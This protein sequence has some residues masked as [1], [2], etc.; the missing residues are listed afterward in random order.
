MSV[1]VSIHDVAPATMPEVAVL[2]GMAERVG[3]PT[4]LLVVP[5]PWRP[6]VMAEA[7]WFVDELHR[8]AGR[9]HEIVVHGWEH[10]AVDDPARSVGRFE[11]SAGRVLTR[12]CAE[13]AELGDREAAARVRSGL[14]AVRA[15]GFDPIGFT[16][17]GW[18]ASP[19]ADRALAAA[20]YRYTTSRTSVIDLVHGVRHPVPAWSQRVG[21]PLTAGVAALVERLVGRRLRAGMDVRI[22]L[23]PGDA[24]VP[25]VVASVARL[26]GSVRPDDS[27]TYGELVT[28]RAR[29]PRVPA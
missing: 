22:P 13:F 15:I 16:P 21:S 20:G 28:A 1:I 10:R 6:P 19:E 4:S 23:H 7:P 3:L 12:G 17:P 18:L 26:L 29:G 14:D 24:R 5:G 25:A 11:R 27:C 9:G 2:V 8:L